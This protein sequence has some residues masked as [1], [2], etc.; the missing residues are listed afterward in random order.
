MTQHM[1]QLDAN[2]RTP[3]DKSAVPEGPTPR[4]VLLKANYLLHKP[5][6]SIHRARVI[7]EIDRE[8]PG[9][10]RIQ[11]RARAFRRCCETAPLAALTAV[12]FESGSLG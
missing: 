6:I 7:T 1:T 4:H 9:L 12:M 10:P 3:Q 8:N 11:L 5:R 2:D